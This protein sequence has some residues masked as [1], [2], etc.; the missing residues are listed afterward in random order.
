MLK[1]ELEQKLIN[2]ELPKIEIVGAIDEIAWENIA[3]SNS[4][5]FLTPI[6]YETQLRVISY[7]DHSI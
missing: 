4:L 5:N 3:N 1:V 2:K 7:S 6:K